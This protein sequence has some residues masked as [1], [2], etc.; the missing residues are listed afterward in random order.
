MLSIRRSSF[1]GFSRKALA[2]ARNARTAKG[3]SSWSVMM[4]TGRS[5]FLATICSCSCNPSMPGVLISAIR[6]AD[7]KFGC[8]V[9]KIS[10]DWKRIG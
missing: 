7:P 8:S 1:I 5:S 10:A 2:P 3:I 6:Q 4:M 9:R